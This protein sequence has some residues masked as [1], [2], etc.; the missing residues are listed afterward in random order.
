MILACKYAATRPVPA[1]FTV[2]TLDLCKAI[3]F[4]IGRHCDKIPAF[5]PY[6]NAL[7]TSKIERPQKLAAARAAWSYWP[8]SERSN[9]AS[10][11]TSFSSSPIARSPSIR[12][13]SRIS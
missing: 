3:A 5:H 1:G 9:A 6:G 7:E 2:L 8:E 13:A 12:I 4:K 10:R 11:E